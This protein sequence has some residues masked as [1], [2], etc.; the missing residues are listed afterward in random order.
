MNTNTNT[1]NKEGK[2]AIRFIIDIVRYFVFLIIGVPAEGE[3]QSI[4]AIA[5]GVLIAIAW[6]IISSKIA[7]ALTG[8][9]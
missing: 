6:L 4:G 9:F 5:L 3:E 8:A 1:T 2:E 7:R